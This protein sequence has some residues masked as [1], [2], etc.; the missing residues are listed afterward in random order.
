MAITKITTTAPERGTFGI[1]CTFTDEDGDALTPDTLT[2]TLTDVDGLVVNSR[3]DIEVSSISSAT[4]IVLS[5]ADL[6]VT[7]ASDRGRKRRFAI[8]GTYDS[9]LGNDMPLTGECEFTIDAYAGVS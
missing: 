4:T 8:E 7:D 1:L 2:W 6:A 3:Q 9:D 5:G